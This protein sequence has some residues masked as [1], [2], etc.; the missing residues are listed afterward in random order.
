MII[1]T[2]VSTIIKHDDQT[3]LTPAV[4]TPHERLRPKWTL[5]AAQ[6]SDYISL[7]Y[8]FE[9]FAPISSYIIPFL[10]ELMTKST[11]SEAASVATQYV[12]LLS[13]V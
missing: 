12:F 10:H 8:F 3:K 9:R 11:D 4:E 7:V 6:R 2:F 5:E 13:L 1:R